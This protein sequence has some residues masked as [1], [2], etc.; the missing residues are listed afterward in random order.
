[1]QVIAQLDPG[2]SERQ[3][4]RLVQTFDPRR[5][6]CSLLTWH[7]TDPLVQS[8]LRQAGCPVYVLNRRRGMGLGFVLDLMRTAWGIRAEVIHG[9]L[10]AGM[11]W[12]VPLAKWCL[13]RPFVLSIRSS[14]NMWP[15]WV[16]VA[17]LLLWRGCDWLLVNSARNRRLFMQRCF[18]APRRVEVQYNI[19]DL[20][21]FQGTDRDRLRAETRAALGLGPQQQVISIVGR[22]RPEKNHLLLLRAVQELSGEFPHLRVLVVGEGPEE[23]RLRAWV[24]GHNMGSVVRFLGRREDVPAL[25]AAADIHVLCSDYEGMPNS[26]LEALAAGRPVVST[27]VGG[28]AE[29]MRTGLDGVLV[30]PGDQAALATAIRRLLNDP[31][32]ASA[33][34]R[35]ARGQIGEKWDTARVSEHLT[36]VYERLAGRR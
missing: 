23:G 27:D 20:K 12:G 4:L 29:V 7:V 9:W 22:L 16:R 11:Y 30:R 26:V 1:M 31:E 2:G 19:I 34:A 28:V 32:Q 18:A 24:G 15:Q 13:H 33:L 10:E 35:R 14:P 17:H 3:L 25:L 5:I 36:E 21:R 8:A 6:R